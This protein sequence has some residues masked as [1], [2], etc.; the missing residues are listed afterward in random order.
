MSK[1]KVNSLLIMLIFF[2]GM[3]SYLFSGAYAIYTR[4]SIVVNFL[5]VLTLFI[6]NLNECK[7]QKNKF[8]II[9]LLQIFILF[10]TLMLKNTG[11]GSILQMLTVTSILLISPNI[12][13]DIIVE[14]ILRYFIP[15]YYILFIFVSKSH[16]NTN[17]VGYIYLCL[18]IL[19]ISVY[20]LHNKGNIS[21]LILMYLLTLVLTYTCK[22]R[23]AM[24]AST[25][26]FFLIIFFEK[27][28]MKK[29]IKN[30]IPVFLVFG[31]LLFAFMYVFLWKSGFYINLTFFVGKGLYSGRNGL[32]EEAF[33]LICKY[34]LF[35][36][37]SKYVLNSF[38]TYAFH[39]AIMMITVTFGVP[40]LFLY[41]YNIRNLFNEIYSNLSSSS[42]LNLLLSS[43]IILFF[44]DF[45]ES[46]T[47]WSNYNGVLLFIIVLLINK[48]KNYSLKDNKLSS[49]YIFEE[50]I[51][52]MGGV[53]RV[54]STIAN[55][56]VKNNN[57][58]LV[59]FYKTRNKEFFE[60]NK[61]IKRNYLIKELNKRS[62]SVE[63]DSVQY[64]FYRIFEKIRDY[65]ILNDKLAQVSNKITKNDI[66]ICGRID[67][68]LKVLP[69]MSNY[70]KVIVRDAIHFDYYKKS[71]Q[72]KVI[73]MFPK[74]VNIFIVSSD[75]SVKVYNDIFKNTNIKLVKIYNPLGIVPNVEYNY[76][77]KT[78]ISVGRYS[79]QKGYENLLQ[80]FKIV[81]EKYPDWKLKIVGAK[82]EKIESIVSDL[83]INNKVDLSEGK[84]NIVKELN[85]SSI[86]VMTS[87]Y[88]GYANALVEAV[89]CGVPSIT[90][91][92]LCGA[93]EIIKDDTMGIIVALKDR[94]NY[95]KG[96]N[97]DEDVKSLSDAMTSLIE[98]RN[99]CDMFSKSGSK[100]ISKTREKKAILKKWSELIDE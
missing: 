70:K 80:A 16:L 75:E 39:N 46:Y 63:H 93:E 10:M 34:P 87:R 65:F 47:Y 98:D 82:D 53:E 89:G 3:I 56:F 1:N 48:N 72:Q 92:W 74:K 35:G 36:V 44:V 52:R 41:F 33:K 64:Y 96:F 31:S 62:S 32:W 78:F 81:S 15:I 83:K 17:Y 6:V 91:N 84:S 76:N 8:I 4:I 11:L 21:K 43:V 30:T 40:N 95:A 45:F 58:E 49:I 61:K 14:K 88:E 73:R 20:N 24:L 12:K 54:I 22:C 50:G 28:N 27:I 67:V 85:S 77:N 5:L 59:S 2:I 13:I 94:N 97:N 60:Y 29:S 69:F 7:K 71:T 26:Y 23:T 100:Y 99:R 19:T 55:E 51:D 38:P 86:F 42:C 90:Y 57:V 68:A 37:G 79:S 66:I 25:I 9:Y 18:F